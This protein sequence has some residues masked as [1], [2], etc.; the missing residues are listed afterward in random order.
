[1]KCFHGSESTVSEK[2]AG[3]FGTPRLGHFCLVTVSVKTG[4]GAHPSF[5]PV[6]TGQGGEA[7]HSPPTCAEVKKTWIGL[8]TSTPLS[9]FTAYCL[10][11]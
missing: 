11:S 5:Y 9:V 8:Y 1:V 10:V 4:S 3:R 6:G 2:E 7:D